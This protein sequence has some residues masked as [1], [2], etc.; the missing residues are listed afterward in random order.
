M[1]ITGTHCF[2]F[3]ITGIHHYYIMLLHAPVVNPAELLQENLLV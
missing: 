3:R 2:I 1:L